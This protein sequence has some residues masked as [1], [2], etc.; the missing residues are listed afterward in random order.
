MIKRKNSKLFDLSYS[1]RGKVVHSMRIGA[2][3][4]KKPKK[5]KKFRRETWRNPKY[6]VYFLT[7]VWYN[8][9]RM[10]VTGRILPVGRQTNESLPLQQ[11]KPG[12]VYIRETVKG[13]IL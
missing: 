4:R 5:N 2:S 8:V 7:V 13:R 1:S 9:F 12:S 6:S 10:H 3:V 11:R